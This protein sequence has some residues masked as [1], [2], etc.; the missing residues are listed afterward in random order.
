MKKTD[1]YLNNLERNYKGYVKE[2]GLWCSKG[3]THHTVQVKT[4]ESY[5]EP[6]L[7]GQNTKHTN[8]HKIA[9]FT[10]GKMCFPSLFSRTS[11]TVTQSTQRNYRLSTVRNFCLLKVLRLCYPNVQGPLDTRSLPSTP[12][13]SSDIAK[14]GN[15][16]SSDFVQSHPGSF[17]II[18]LR[19]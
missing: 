6:R 18:S 16:Y 13:H 14:R 1:V 17:P 8:K 4:M 5:R 19:R 2:K 3:K 7:S 12:G 11:M 15:I 10:S 9:A